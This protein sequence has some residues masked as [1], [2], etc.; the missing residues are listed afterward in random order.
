MKEDDE[1]LSLPFTFS[2]PLPLSGVNEPAL[3]LVNKIFQCAFLFFSQIM[4]APFL[5]FFTENEDFHPE[6]FTSVDR[7]GRHR[8]FLS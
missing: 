8:I 6:G 1:D 5:L 7:N 2:P 3:F 4:K